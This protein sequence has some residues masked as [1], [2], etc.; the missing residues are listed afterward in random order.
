MSVDLTSA[1]QRHREDNVRE[2]GRADEA[3]GFIT[4][5]VREGT[6]LE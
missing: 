4:I 6:S 3:V 2:L 1:S 5:Q